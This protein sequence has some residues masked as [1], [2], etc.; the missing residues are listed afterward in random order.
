MG[1]EKSVG[2]E[3]RSRDQEMSDLILAAQIMKKVKRATTTA[4]LNVGH[5]ETNP[6]VKAA[7]FAKGLGALRLLPARVE[8]KA[9]FS[10]RYHLLR[11]LV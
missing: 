1:L 3:E 11:D 10:N 5:N 4:R 8:A 7:N 2:F 6:G 9:V